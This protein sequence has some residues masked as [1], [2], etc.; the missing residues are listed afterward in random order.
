[1]GLLDLP[2]ALNLSSL[3]I[4]ALNLSNLM[5]KRLQC[6]VGILVDANELPTEVVAL[7]RRDQVSFRS[8]LPW[9]RG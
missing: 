9:R 7:I 1:M 4:I 3:M 2:V 8:T 6:A 5:I